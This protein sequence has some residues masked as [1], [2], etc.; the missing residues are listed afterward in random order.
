[1]NKTSKPAAP[2]RRERREQLRELR[3]VLKRI[4]YRKPPA[5]LQPKQRDAFESVA[6]E[7]LYGG[8]AYGGKSYLFR[9]LAIAF[10]RWVP[11]IQIYLFRRQ[12]GDLFKNHM[13]GPTGFPAMLSEAI[14]SGEARILQGEFKQIRFAHKGAPDSVIHLC[15][16]QHEQNVYKYQGADIHIL[17]VDEL[18]QWMRGMYTFL[19]SR[20][21][22]GSLKV[23]KWLKHRLPMILAGANPGG[24]GHNWVKADFVDIHPPMQMK[25]MPDDEGGMLRQFIPAKLED[26]PIGIENDPGYEKRLD[27][28]DNKALAKAMR[29]GDWDII[30]GGFF[31]DLWDRAK[32]VIKPFAIPKSWRIDRSFDWGSSKPFSVGWW[33]ESDGSPADVPNADGEMERRHFARGTIF[34]IAEW[35]GCNRDPKKPNEGLKLLAKDVAKGIVA[36]EKIWRDQYGWKVH[37][38]AADAAIYA[39]ENGNCIADDMEDEGVKWL[40]ADKSPG[41]RKNGWEIGRKLMK[42]ARDNPVED[43]G[44]FVFDTCV[45]WIRIVPVLPRDEK[46]TDDVD[47]DAEDHLG[48]ESRYRWLTPK[49]PRVRKLR[50]AA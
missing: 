35:Y 25:Q 44:M 27:G 33:A 14:E 6:T 23:P 9:R 8:A 11:G 43:K 2:S 36:R 20:V 21:R 42:G 16:C 32:H 38:G 37:P 39:T 1:M 30:A 28:L 4:E 12:F 10:A 24:I 18:T 26:N 50:Q 48:D 46:L 22:L 15:H 40:E 13:E 7:K 34:R 41:S 29:N 47:T 49:P 3:R 31:D 17:L 5:D 45:D 19:R